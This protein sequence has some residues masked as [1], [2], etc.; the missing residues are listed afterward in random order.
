MG[1]EV[2]I[3]LNNLAQKFEIL[4]SYLRRRATQLQGRFHIHTSQLTSHKTRPKSSTL[5][6]QD[7]TEIVS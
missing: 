1:Y 2:L 7:I 6:F 5:Q 3:G 4:M